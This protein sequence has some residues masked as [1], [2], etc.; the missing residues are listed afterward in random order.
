VA[1]AVSHLAAPSKPAPAKSVTKNVNPAAAKPHT[2][3]AVV[4]GQK[5]PAQPPKAPVPAPAHL[6][7]IS[8]VAP[9]PHAQTATRD[10]SQPTATLADIPVGHEHY[11][12]TDVN[13]DAF[14]NPINPGQASSQD[15]E[16]GSGSVRAIHNFSSQDLKPE[17]NQPQYNQE[18]EG[19]GGLEQGVNGPENPEEPAEDVVRD[20]TLQFQVL[21]FGASE[22]RFISQG[23]DEPAHDVAPLG[24]SGY[25]PEVP[26]EGATDVDNET[27]PGFGAAGNQDDFPQDR[28][29]GDETVQDLN[30]WQQEEEN[31]AEDVNSNQGEGTEPFAQDGGD[32]EHQDDGIV[33]APDTDENANEGDQWNN[34]EGTAPQDE[35]A[36]QE[37]NDEDQT[38]PPDLIPED[39]GQDDWQNNDGGDQEGGD[40]GG[41]DEGGNDAGG[42]ES[43]ER[44]NSYGGSDGGE[45][46]QVGEDDGGDEE[47]EDDDE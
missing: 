10:I 26:I 36:G 23:D 17:I 39:Q 15:N 14:G 30:D 13:F 8:P 3:K 2:A 20:E 35:D 43:S 42:D 21:Q 27:T 46:Q 24:N 33:G 34:D 9:H 41:D 37:S 45:E 6:A 18:D 22:E 5:T 32:D 31:G 25:L 11:Y 16:G 19:Y 28:Q 4:V 47:E 12:P 40:D 29:V 1:Q 38:Q 44:G 7:T